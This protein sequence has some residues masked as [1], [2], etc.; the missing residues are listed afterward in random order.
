MD[1]AQYQKVEDAVRK[2]NSIPN[3]IGAGKLWFYLLRQA[4]KY[5]GITLWLRYVRWRYPC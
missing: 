4:L 3:G 2:L 1:D 5:L